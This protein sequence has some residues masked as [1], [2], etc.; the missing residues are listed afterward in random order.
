MRRKIVQHVLH[1]A[2]AKGFD[3]GAKAYVRGRPSYPSEA[4]EWVVS[5]CDITATSVVVDVGAGTGKFT[6][7]LHPFTP[8]VIAI[9]PVAAMREACADLDVRDGTAEA[10]PLPDTSVDALVCA[11]AFH[12]FDGPRA[13]AEMYRI[14]KPAGVLCMLWNTWDRSAG[15]SVALDPLIEAHRGTAPKH[16]A[17]LWKKVFDETDLFTPL[18]HKAFAHTHI[19][20]PAEMLDRVMSISFVAALEEST[21]NKVSERAQDIIAQH[22]DIFCPYTTDIFWTKSQKSTQ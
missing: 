18:K 8:H 7:L 12:W 5:V 19:L 17:R 1:P 13:L 15:V 10:I 21:R 6:R 16:S 3:V 14:L 20:T 4:V 22:K 9:E 11:T 2:A